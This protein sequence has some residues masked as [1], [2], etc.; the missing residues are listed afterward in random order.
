MF[1]YSGLNLVNPSHISSQPKAKTTHML[2]HP[3]I[4]QTT[5]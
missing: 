5:T 3:K 2:S 1:A 4:N